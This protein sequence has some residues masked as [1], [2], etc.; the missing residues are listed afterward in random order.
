M[1]TDMSASP[2]RPKIKLFKDLFFPPSQTP[3]RLRWRLVS[4]CIYHSTSVSALLPLTFSALE[5]NW[6]LS[7]HWHQSPALL[8]F[9]NSSWIMFTTFQSGYDG[10]GKTLYVIRKYVRRL[11]HEENTGVA[12]GGFWSLQFFFFRFF[13]PFKTPWDLP[14]FQTGEMVE[15]ERRLHY[16]V[17]FIIWFFFFPICCSLKV[18]F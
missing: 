12:K 6:T 15:Q 4:G 17:G 9:W 14:K 11:F 13:F 10:G 7:Y 5:W 1:I 8:F 3:A 16:N 2:K 18:Q